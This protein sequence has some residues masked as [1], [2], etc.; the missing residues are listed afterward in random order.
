MAAK[1][2]TQ[3]E[4][5]ELKE[6]EELERL[7]AAEKSGQLRQ[8]HS[9]GKTAVTHGVEGLALGHG[10]TI[11]G[12][13]NKGLD[14][15]AGDSSPYA[16]DRKL[17]E[18]GFTGDL[19]EKGAYKD[20]VDDRRQLLQETYDDNP[21]TALASDFAG[22]LATSAVA[23]TLT[24]GGFSATAEGAIAGTGYGDADTLQDAAISGTA[25]ALLGKYGGKA[26]GAGG[27]L[28]AKGLKAGGSAVGG[29]VK[30]VA[31]G[32]ADAIYNA[33]KIKTGAKQPKK[34]KRAINRLEEK[35]GIFTG[36]GGISITPEKAKE[37][38]D[39]LANNIYSKL[40]SI[41]ESVSK[42][43][44]PQTLNKTFTPLTS[45]IEEMYQKTAR[46]SNS[47]ELSNKL[48]NTLNDMKTAMNSG[49]YKQVIS[50]LNND[51]KENYISYT[52]ADEM[53]VPK[54]IRGKMKQFLSQ[55]DE[56]NA[57]LIGQVAGEGS[58]KAFKEG[59]EDLSSYHKVNKLV[60][61]NVD[62]DL[63]IPKPGIFDLTASTMINYFTNPYLASAYLVGS[64]ALKQPRVQGA[65]AKM[66]K[67]TD[68]SF[69]GARKVLQSPVADI[70][71]K[72]LPEEVQHLVNK[73]E[74]GVVLP[75][76][77]QHLVVKGVT[78]QFPEFFKYSEYE[79]L[80]GNQ[81][82]D[83]SDVEMEKKKISSNPSMSNIEKF[84]RINSLNKDGTMLDNPNTASGTLTPADEGT[85]Q[86]VGE[87][88]NI[89]SGIMNGSN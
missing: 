47:K 7:E 18:Q 76:V 61:D 51:I 34:A 41:T 64:T 56:A 74:A 67:A 12:L 85:K 84:K 4:L 22:G 25:G 57:S 88:L 71:K 29:A 5:T 54:E 78:S 59:M 38:L 26:L 79:S 72:N 75:S 21:K 13:I 16:Q 63:P 28:A 23:N 80:V 10:D 45:E 31:P 30:K 77:H 33:L 8:K 17:R 15:L 60:T 65:L 87:A 6:L 1:P 11:S 14:K 52:S 43:V 86:A 42:N 83:P 70:V 24:G 55:F 73:M 66:Y 40:D 81:L 68:R 39:N 58:E 50:V 19:D 53:K 20:A 48:A 82:T 36:Q 2:L 35:F 89:G 62:K 37:S 46:I 27:K 49:D 9:Q 32:T 3:A 69:E 44:N